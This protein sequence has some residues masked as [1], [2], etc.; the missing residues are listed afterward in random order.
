MTLRG[1]VADQVR[2][3]VGT[4]ISHTVQVGPLAV[5]CLIVMLYTYAYE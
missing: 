3:L 1:G 4:T 5:L 2:N